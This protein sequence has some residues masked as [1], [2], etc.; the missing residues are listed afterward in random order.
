MS[1]STTAQHARPPE[2]PEDHDPTAVRS[3]S[4]EAIRAM[5]G[6]SMALGPGPRPLNPLMVTGRAI[7][8]AREVR[9]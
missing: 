7:N 4:V 1:S 8:G 6:Q 3:A 2:H 5:N 9:S